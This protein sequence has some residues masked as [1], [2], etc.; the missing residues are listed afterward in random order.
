MYFRNISLDSCFQMLY[1]L[2]IKYL[3]CSVILNSLM[4]CNSK[5]EYT[6]KDHDM[7]TIT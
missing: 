1:L 6:N 2:L 3:Y 4:S 7:P 5:Q